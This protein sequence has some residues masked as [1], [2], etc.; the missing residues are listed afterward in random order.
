MTNATPNN[1]IFRYREGDVCQLSPQFHDDMDAAM[2]LEGVI[3]CLNS[4]EIAIPRWLDDMESIADLD[5]MLVI[6]D[7]I[8]EDHNEI[9]VEIKRLKD[10]GIS[11]PLAF[12]PAELVLT[13]YPPTPMQR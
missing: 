13:D 10:A 2:Q 12:S 8:D 3:D 5:T 1:D 9:Y 11:C 7:E 4:E 6:I